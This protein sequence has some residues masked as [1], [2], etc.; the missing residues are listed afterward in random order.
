MLLQVR[1]WTRVSQRENSERFRSE[2]NCDISPDVSGFDLQNKDRPKKSAIINKNAEINFTA[3]LQRNSVVNAEL[4]QV[5][6]D[7]NSAQVPE[8]EVQQSFEDKALVEMKW[9]DNMLNY[10]F[11]H[12]T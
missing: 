2:H 11:I 8:I 1:D 6:P 9:N 12:I 3:L 10:I 7:S 5:Q 4:K